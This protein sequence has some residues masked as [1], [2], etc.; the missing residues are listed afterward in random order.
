M[1]VRACPIFDGAYAGLGTYEE[2]SEL[3]VA[4]RLR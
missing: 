3:D 1:R 2:I 4:L